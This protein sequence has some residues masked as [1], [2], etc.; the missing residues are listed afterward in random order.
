MGWLLAFIDSHLNP[1]RSLDSE[2]ISLDYWADGLL[3]FQS[4]AGGNENRREA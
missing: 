3:G 2:Q 4:V 1:N